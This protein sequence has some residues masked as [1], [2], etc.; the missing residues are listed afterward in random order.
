MSDK[1]PRLTH[2]VSEFLDE[3]EKPLAALDLP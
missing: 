1:F 2:E 3:V